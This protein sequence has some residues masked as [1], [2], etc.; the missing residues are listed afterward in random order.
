MTENRICSFCSMPIAE[1]GEYCPQCG[2]RQQDQTTQTQYSHYR[3]PPPPPPPPWPSRD[4]ANR[5]IKGIALVVMILL[6][7]LVLVLV[8]GSLLV[9]RSYYQ[10][11]VTPKVATTPAVVA[12]P[13]TSVPS[14]DNPYPTTRGT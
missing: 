14:N 4:R 2:Q 13:M 10:P 5:Q 1:E 3:T 12:N 9:V 6:A 8:F 7:I 11:T